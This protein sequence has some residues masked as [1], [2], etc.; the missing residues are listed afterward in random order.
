MS[1]VAAVVIGRHE[2]PRLPRCLH[3]V[4]GQCDPVVY[5]DTASS[6]GSPEAARQLGA[7]VVALDVSIPFTFGRARNIGAARALEVAPGVAYVQFVDADCEMIAGWMEQASAALESAPDLGAVFGLLHERF[8]SDSLYDRLF[9]LEFDPRTEE[10]QTFGGLAMLRAVAYE[11]VG[12]YREDLQTFEDHELSLRLRRSGWQ[13][14]RLETGMAIHEA[15]MTTWRQWWTR[16][17]RA[18]HGRAKLVALYGADAPAQWHRAAASIWFWGALVPLA[19]L[20]ALY[21]CGIVGMLL[22]LL[23]YG[24]LVGRI[25]LRM[26]RRGMPAADAAL[27]ATARAVGKFPQLHGAMS[28]LWTRPRGT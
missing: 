21:A 23:L 2:G 14:R 24:V 10:A 25:L 7:E 22:P 4:L 16:E 8:P 9:A 17:R 3:S 12:R 11:Q 27:F 13:I 6:D 19:G 15:G 1:R 28:F 18:G 20:A 26:R 5:V